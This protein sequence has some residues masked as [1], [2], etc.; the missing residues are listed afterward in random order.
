LL[1]ESLTRI[2]ITQTLIR[3]QEFILV[4]A[5]TEAKNHKKINYSHRY[6]LLPQFGAPSPYS[7]FFDELFCICPPQKIDHGHLGDP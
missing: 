4:A 5:I 1:H 6:D 7:N 2:F 3:I